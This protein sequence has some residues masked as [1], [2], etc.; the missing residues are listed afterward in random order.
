MKALVERKDCP[1]ELLTITA[2]EFTGKKYGDI[3]ETRKRLV[4]VAESLNLPF[5][6][7]VSFIVRHER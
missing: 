2:V 4:S 5:P 1:I 7:K 6:F 3:D